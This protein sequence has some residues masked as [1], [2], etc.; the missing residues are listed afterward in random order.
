MSAYA[1]D[2]IISRA[3]G[4]GPFSALT[5]GVYCIYHR[6]KPIEGMH[7]TPTLTTLPDLLLQEPSAQDCRGDADASK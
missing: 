1:T 3:G 4:E 2:V 5:K 7:S 6:L